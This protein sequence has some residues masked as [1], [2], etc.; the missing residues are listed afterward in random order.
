VGTVTSMV[1]VLACH[2]RRDLTVRCL[3]SLFATPAPGLELSV[4][5]VDDGSTDGTAA[6]VT[7][8][9]YPVTVVTG[10]GQ[11]YWSRSM[12]EGERVAEAHDP[13]WILWLNDDVVLRPEAFLRWTL[14]ARRHPDAILVGAMWSPAGELVV[15]GGFE[16]PDPASLAMTRLRIPT[17]EPVPVS[18]FH[19]NFVAVP[20]SARRL[21]GPI[22][23]TWP[24]Y[25]ADLDYALR[26]AEAGVHILLLP[27]LA[28]DCEPVTPAWRDASLPVAPRVRAA[29][30]RK[31]WPVRAHWRLHRRHAR[32]RWPL[33][34]W[35]PH[36]MALRGERRRRP[37]RPQ[38]YGATGA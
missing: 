25:Y 8:L 24:H 27:G 16:W 6:A 21:I 15:Y 37:D 3:H 11:W 18:G 23:G 22:D 17:D 14:T 29:F 32:G 19:G 1:A 20:R 38:E 26:A 4:V 9:G 5:L 28:G 30:G 33:R 35:R 36:W 31:G 13:D 2:N 7:S 34:A 10:D 12:A